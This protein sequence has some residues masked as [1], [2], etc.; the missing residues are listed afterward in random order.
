MLPLLFI[1]LDLKTDVIFFTCPFTVLLDLP[2]GT[3]A[4]TLD[5][6]AESW[7]TVAVVPPFSTSELWPYCFDF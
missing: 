2:Y 1:Y 4:R 6:V 5:I 3:R 7:Y